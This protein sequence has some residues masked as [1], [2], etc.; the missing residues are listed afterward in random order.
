MK[1][2]FNLT[3][4]EF[5]IVKM[6]VFNESYK[7]KQNELTYYLLVD[8]DNF[9]HDYKFKCNKLFITPQTTKSH[10]KKS[11]PPKL[12]MRCEMIK[13]LNLK[14]TFSAQKEAREISDKNLLENLNKWILCEDWKHITFQTIEYLIKGCNSTGQGNANGYFKTHYHGI[15]YCFGFFFQRLNIS[16]KIKMKYSDVSYKQIWNE[17]FNNKN[18]TEINFE[19]WMEQNKLS[20]FFKQYIVN[21]KNWKTINKELDTHLNLLEQD[22]MQL[23]DKITELRNRYRTDIK[24][25]FK[26]CGNIINHFFELADTTNCEYAHIKPV[27]QIRNEYLKDKHQEILN[28]IAD[29][30]NFL[31]LS[32][33]VHKLYDKKYF[34]WTSD[35][36]LNNIKEYKHKDVVGFDKI[37]PEVITDIQKYLND[38]DYLIHQTKN[39]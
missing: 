4:Y 18:V 34:Y 10:E 32:P 12:L 2:E 27:Y 19:K 37:R 38:Y 5:R 35:G 20:H 1:P 13:L 7:Q 15:A 3:N 29:S 6:E 21:S 9:I 31:P 25:R 17:Y 39:D 14:H 22:F 36:E 26:K 30:N 23:E 16:K 8:A 24:K 28:Q 33:N 11:M